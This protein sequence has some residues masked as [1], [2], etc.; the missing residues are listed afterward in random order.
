MSEERETEERQI[1]NEPEDELV[2]D[3]VAE[4]SDDPEPAQAETTEGYKDKYLRAMADLDNLRKRMAR[5]TN[6]ARQRERETILREFTSV[7]DNF[8]RALDS[9]GA[10]TSP[11]LEGIQA[12]RTQMLD[13]L[14]KFGA[15]PFGSAGE[16]FDPARYE[17]VAT[18][19]LPD[20][21]EGTIADVVEIGYE[22]EDGPILRPARVI[23][24]THG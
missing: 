8:D 9:V 12:I 19:N 11:W 16:K 5:E 17:A 2:D 20:K 3:G 1:D 21:P 23:V 13:A 24:V 14:K 7:I 4:P 22:M 6:L 18:V 10:E 15:T